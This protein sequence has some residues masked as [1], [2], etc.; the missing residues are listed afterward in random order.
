[1]ERRAMITIRG[2]QK[3]EHEAPQTLEFVTGGMLQRFGRKLRVSYEESDLTG[4]EGVTAA[5]EVDGDKVTLE[6]TGKVQSKMVF[7]EGQKMESLYSMDVGAL[8]L[9]ITARKVKPALT[10]D[11]GSI[12]LEYGVELERTY[13]GF[14]TFDIQVKTMPEQDK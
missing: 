11:G 12:F 3:A 5:F 4:T 7:V 9:G 14:N 13:L 8:L 1:M 10:D 2:T 6:R